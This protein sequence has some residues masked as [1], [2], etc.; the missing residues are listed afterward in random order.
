MRIAHNIPD[1]EFLL[2]PCSRTNEPTYSLPARN[3]PATSTPSHR[4]ASSIQP[5]PHVNPVRNTRMGA[6][7][8]PQ[9]TSPTTTTRP[10]NPSVA[11]IRSLPTPS[12]PSPMP[13]SPLPPS[14]QSTHPVQGGAVH[15]R[16][17]MKQRP[18]GITKMGL[19]QAMGLHVDKA[20][21]HAYNKFRVS[22]PSTPTLLLTL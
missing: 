3:R 6:T 19:K 12:R 20:A 16:R 8:P 17:R 1:F 21:R 11:Q 5:P 10:L 22:V 4:T 15:N 9:P 14:S 13:C 18:Q 2:N 7:F